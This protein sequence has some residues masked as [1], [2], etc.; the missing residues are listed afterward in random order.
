[1]SRKSQTRMRPAGKILPRNEGIQLAKEAEPSGSFTS[2]LEKAMQEI[3]TVTYWFDPV[4]HPEP[5]P[6]TIRFSGRRADVKGRLQAGDRFS[7]DEMIEKV[8]PGSGPIS[9]TAKVYDINPGEWVVTA[10]VQ[11]SPDKAS[12]TRKQ[13]NTMLVTVPQNPIARLWH[14]W[15]PPLEAGTP[16]KT[17]LILFARIPG[18]LTGIWGAMATLGIILALLLQ[19]LVIFVDHLAVD[20]WWAVS[21][22]AIVVGIIGAKSWYIILYR[23][24]HLVNGWCI[25]GFITGATVTAVILLAVFKIP[26]GIFLD[27]TTPGLLLAMAVGRVGCFFAGCCGGPPT[28]ASWGVWS[29]DQRVGARR[30]P[31]QLMECTLALSLGLLTLV[32]M[33]SYG[34]RGGAYFAGALAAYTLVRQGI[35]HLRAE[36]RKT[37]RGMPITATLAT[38]LL[39]AA[40]VFLVR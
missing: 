8:V 9:V 33:L 20:Q 18:I 24:E 3:L 38:L 25:Q 23:R 13:E 28:A 14:R 17:K 10:H 21:L 34:P 16:I 30:V 5:Y 22:G 37:K 11:G 7:Q 4:S 2:L 29:S 26:D 31:T 40:I 39:V 1:M 19:F 35:L 27:A 15:A 36:A 6:V 32:A 12:G